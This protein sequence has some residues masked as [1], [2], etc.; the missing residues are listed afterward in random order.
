MISPIVVEIMGSGLTGQTYDLH[1]K[2]NYGEV[3]KCTPKP[4]NGVSSPSIIHLFGNIIDQ[5]MEA[6]SQDSKCPLR[7]QVAEANEC[8]KSAAQTEAKRGNPSKK[9]LEKLYDFSKKKAYFEEVDVYELEESP[10]PNKF[11]WKIDPDYEF[12]EHDLAA[13]LARRRRSKLFFR[14]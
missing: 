5:T 6:A 1:N 3:V 4:I 14:T 7:N 9:V 8:K 12:P 13:I 2:K 11:I 10:T